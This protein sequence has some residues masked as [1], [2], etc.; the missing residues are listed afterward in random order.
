MV[1]ILPTNSLFRVKNGDQPKFTENRLAELK[2]VLL[3]LLLEYIA[4]PLDRTMDS[5]WKK[6]KNSENCHWSRIAL[7]FIS[8]SM[9]SCSNANCSGV[10]SITDA[11]DSRYL[12]M[13]AAGENSEISML[14]DKVIKVLSTG[15]LP[16]A[17]VITW[18]VV[19]MIF[20][21]GKILIR[22]RSRHRR[23]RSRRIGVCNGVIIL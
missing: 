19:W 8:V 1:R 18:G 23:L 21:V 22:S 13:E 9:R 6:I 16:I 4:L 14:S 10:L 15:F 20:K 11:H 2:E 12:L 17:L 7:S 3:L 5:S